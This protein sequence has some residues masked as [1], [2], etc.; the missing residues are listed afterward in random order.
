[1]EGITTVISQT[2]GQMHE[3]NPSRRSVSRLPAPRFFPYSAGFPADFRPVSVH[4]DRDPC[5][6]HDR[7]AE[8]TWQEKWACSFNGWQMAVTNHGFTVSHPN[9]PKF[10]PQNK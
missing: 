1:M 2:A 3:Q 8:R 10:R 9:Q 6:P 7:N 5:S 4:E